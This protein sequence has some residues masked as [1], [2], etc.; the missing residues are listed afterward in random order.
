MQQ[1]KNP[2]HR[3]HLP[4]LTCAYTLA[5][6]PTHMPDRVLV[7]QW[8]QPHARMSAPGFLGPTPIFAFLTRSNG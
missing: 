7:G 4:C 1:T 6:E 2:D 8:H 3:H 5:L